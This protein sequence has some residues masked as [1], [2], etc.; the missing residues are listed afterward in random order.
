MHV[1]G[2]SHLDKSGRITLT[3]FFSPEEPPHDVVFAIDMDEEPSL[4]AVWKAEEHQDFGAKVHLDSKN[5]IILPK[6]LREEL[7]DCKDIL[8][9]HDEGQ[10]YL[11]PQTGKIL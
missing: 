8:F 11:M 2:K 10:R 4:I 9:I 5:R 6:W 1:F 3:D 7:S